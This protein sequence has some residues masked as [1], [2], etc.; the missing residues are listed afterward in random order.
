MLG[1]AGVW[2]YGNGLKPNFKKKLKPSC[3]IKVIR[4]VFL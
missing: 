1:E 4:K 3:P 2:N